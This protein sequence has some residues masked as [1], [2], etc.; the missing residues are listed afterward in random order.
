[1]RKPG[2][3]VVIPIFNLD[4]RR[5]NNLNFI[6]KH[7]VKTKLKILIIEQTPG[8]ISKDYTC[9]ENNI[10]HQSLRS[11]GENIK[12]S[13]LINNSCNF[14]TTTHVWIVDCD[15]Y[16]DFCQVDITQLLNHDYVQPYFYA[17]DLTSEET[18]KC[19]K[20]SDISKIKYYNGLENDHR[21]VNIYGA[22]SFIFNIE[23]YQD[24]GGMDE[25]YEGWGHED[26]DLFLKLHT[27]DNGKVIHIVENLKGVHLWHPDPVNKS[28][29]SDLNYKIFSDKGY[30]ID[31]ATE[32][33]LKY[34][35]PTWGKR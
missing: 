5:Y 22:L 29:T 19:F 18:I 17:R 15:F 32:Y 23:K 33:T 12:K 26:I 14:V 9:I 11:P 20:T 16:M 8:K 2:I 7:L 13:W 27:P 28:K 3:T 31:L 35:Y 6:L 24:M 10:E 4:E 21:H 30:S 34:Y 1:M 25:R